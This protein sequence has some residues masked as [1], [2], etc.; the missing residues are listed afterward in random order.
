MTDYGEIGLALAFV[1]VIILWFNHCIGK[2]ED[3]IEKLS[4]KG[5]Q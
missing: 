1:Y 3:F 5:P 2:L 4:K